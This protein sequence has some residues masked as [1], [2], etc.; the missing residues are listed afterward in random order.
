[1][2][3]KQK[4]TR[5]FNNFSVNSFVDYKN[6]SRSWMTSGIFTEYLFDW[7]KELIKKEQY[8]PNSG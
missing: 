8:L 5:C 3:G 6:A 1:V 7:Y 2:I 4:K